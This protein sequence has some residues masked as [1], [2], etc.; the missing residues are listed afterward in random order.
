MKLKI[1]RRSR[2][3]AEKGRP[4]RTPNL[5]VSALGLISKQ[6]DNFCPPPPLYIHTC[7]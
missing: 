4:D 3:G 1:E 2:L 5:G 7:G 6:W